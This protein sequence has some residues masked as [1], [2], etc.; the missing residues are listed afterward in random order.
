MV[1]AL[2]ADGFR[3]Y[4][5]AGHR[6]PAEELL[7]ERA[8]MLISS[9]L[10]IP[11]RVEFSETELPKSGSG[12]ILK[13]ILRERFWAPD[14]F[15]CIISVSSSFWQADTLRQVRLCASR[16]ARLAPFLQRISLHPD[17]CGEFI[18][19]HVK[20]YSCPSKLCSSHCDTLSIDDGN[21][22]ACIFSM[23]S[24]KSWSVNVT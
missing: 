19:R 15:F 10:K 14:L 13:R 2:I 3:N 16:A 22:F 21:W 12:K 6:K 5:R 23:K 17:C 20:P 24:F 18:L 7:V 4:L 8:N 9:Q 1:A 11:R